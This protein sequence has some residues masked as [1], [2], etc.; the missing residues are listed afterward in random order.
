MW[1]PPSA[2]S[3]DS[4]SSEWGLTPRVFERLF[5]RIN[6]EQAKHSDKQLNY[7]CHRSFLEASISNE[8]ITDLLDPTQKNLQIREDVK[9]G[10][11]VDC[12][13]EEY[14][15]TMKDVIRLLTKVH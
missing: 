11:Y 6:E 4:S 1:G 10:I 3:E 14:V 7:Q 13:T 8:Q 5:S 12:L 9:A 2:L 15:Y